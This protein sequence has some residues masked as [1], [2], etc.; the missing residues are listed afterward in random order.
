MYLRVRKLTLVTYPS[1]SMALAMRLCVCILA[2]L[3]L[4]TCAI[5]CFNNSL[6]RHDFHREKDLD[7]QSHDVQSHDVLFP[8]GLRRISQRL[9]VAEISLNESDTKSELVYEQ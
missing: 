4:I 1:K 8:K 6:C 7:V 9:E 5:F 3:M 2:L